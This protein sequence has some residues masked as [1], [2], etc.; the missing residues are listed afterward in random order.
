MRVHLCFERLCQYRQCCSHRLLCYGCVFE[1]QRKGG[2][3]WGRVDEDLVVFEGTSHRLFDQ[4]FVHEVFLLQIH[5][6]D[7]R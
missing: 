5:N 2:E 7:L 1:S 6:N 3:V 4:K